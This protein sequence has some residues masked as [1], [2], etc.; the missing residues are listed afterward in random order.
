V[1][2][3]GDTVTLNSDGHL[4]T[5][6][7]VAEDVITCAWSVRG[8]VKSKSFPIAAVKKAV[9]AETVK[10][11]R[12]AAALEKLAAKFAESEEKRL[13]NTVGVQNGVHLPISSIGVPLSSSVSFERAGNAYSIVGKI[14]DS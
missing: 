8:D 9:S 6:V 3:V 4:M 11:A 5:V 12:R 2:K 1:F 13:L 10:E 7:S 14:K